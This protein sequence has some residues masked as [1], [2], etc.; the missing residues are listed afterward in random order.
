MTRREGPQILLVDDEPSITELLRHLLEADGEVRQ[1]HGVCEALVAMSARRPDVLV[2][3]LQMDEGGGKYLLAAVA[4]EHPSVRRL[5]YSAAPVSQLVCLVDS[6]LAD[7]A[8]CKSER[9]SVLLG[10]VRRLL[11]TVAAQ[12]RADSIRIVR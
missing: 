2:T 6:G 1:A 10:E 4:D 12:P 5:V 11:G 9:W 7:A 3:D 8:V